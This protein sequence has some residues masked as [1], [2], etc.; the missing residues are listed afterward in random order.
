MDARAIYFF[1]RMN[2][3]GDSVRFTAHE[4]A[5]RRSAKPRAAPRDDF[6]KQTGGSAST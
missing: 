2:R 5:T 3:R 1:S 4:T 6:K